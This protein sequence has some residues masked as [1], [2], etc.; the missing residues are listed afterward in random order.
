MKSRRGGR[1]RPSRERSERRRSG[2]SGKLHRARKQSRLTTPDECVRGYVFFSCKLPSPHRSYSCSGVSR[3]G[4]APARKCSKRS[5]QNLLLLQFLAARAP[6]V[7]ITESHITMSSANHKLRLIGALAV[8]ATLVLAVSCRG[9]FTNPTVSS[10][11]IDPPNPTVSVS[12]TRQLTAAGTDSNGNPLTLTGGTSCTG[13]TVCWSSDTPS[14]ATVSVGGLLTGVA[15]GTSTIS[16]ASGT[17]SATTTATI[18][19]DNVTSVVLGPSGITSFSIAQ[20]TTATGS[21][22][23]T[24]TATAGGQQINVTT[25]VTWTA[26]NTSLLTVQNGV[27]PMCVTSLAMSGTTTVFATYISGNNTIISNSVTVTVQ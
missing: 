3:A 9:F 21:D 16:A 4:S 27:D 8:L 23:L 24:A 2:T 17:A 14:V 10:I 13:T 25:S 22:C 11:T 15:P 1:I 26:A 18:T 20:S 5:T 19:L 7:H 12:L 6:D